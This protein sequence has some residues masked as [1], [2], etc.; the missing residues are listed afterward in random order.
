MYFCIE[1]FSI[2]KKGGQLLISEAKQGRAWLYLEGDL[3][4]TSAKLRKKEKSDLEA[5]GSGL[6]VTW[7]GDLLGIPGAVSFGFF[8]LILLT[9]L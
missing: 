8:I 3:R 1:I 2:K 5:A 6:V 4:D 9:G 7:M